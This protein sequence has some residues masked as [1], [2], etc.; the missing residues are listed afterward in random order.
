MFGK[1][2]EGVSPAILALC[3][4][5][6][7]LSSV[8]ED[9]VRRLYVNS[10]KETGLAS[11]KGKSL[12]VL[13]VCLSASLKVPLGCL[14]LVDKKDMPQEFTC[15]DYSNAV[16]LKTL[17]GV[18]VVFSKLRCGSNVT[19]LDFKSDSEP[20]SLGQVGNPILI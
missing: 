3:F 13:S 20:M 5:G 10:V 18:W 15:A 9:G 6:F 11:K 4:L 12:G 14:W 19:F 8:E 1:H 16:S 7:S 2:S 17:Q